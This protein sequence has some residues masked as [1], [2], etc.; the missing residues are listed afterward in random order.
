MS[1]PFDTSRLP[2][3]GGHTIFQ[4][5][6]LSQVVPDKALATMKVLLRALTAKIL[7]GHRFVIR[8]LLDGIRRCKSVRRAD[9]QEIAAQIGLRTVRL[10]PLRHVL[11]VEILIEARIVTRIDHSVVYELALCGSDVYNPAVI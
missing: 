9:F 6:A 8:F 4:L 2:I 1:E 7:S 11:R 10:A 5:T 3:H